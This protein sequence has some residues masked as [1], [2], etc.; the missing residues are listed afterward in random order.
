MTA[1]QPEAALDEP[2]GRN[3]HFRDA[4]SVTHAAQTR[5]VSVNP[6]RPFSQSVLPERERALSFDPEAEAQD[7]QT[8]LSVSAANPWKST[9]AASDEAGGS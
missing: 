6:A 1:P 2:A 9:R 4:A 8:Q 3:A 5:P 7:F